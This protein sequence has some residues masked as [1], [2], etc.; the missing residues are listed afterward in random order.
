VNE[1]AKP[2]LLVM[3]IGQG[4]QTYGRYAEN[5]GVNPIVILPPD[6]NPDSGGPLFSTAQIKIRP[7][8]RKL[9]L[10]NMYGSRTQHERTFALTVGL[11]EL[12]Q[13]QVPKKAGLTMEDFPLTLPIPEGYDHKRDMITKNT[14]GQWWLIWIAASDAAP[15]RPPAMLKTISALWV[16]NGSSKG[17]R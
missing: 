9:K 6:A 16:K 4:H 10:A 2:G 17:G 12:N 8:G 13:E 5:K 15:A 3:N 7:T 1:F 14:A 11:A